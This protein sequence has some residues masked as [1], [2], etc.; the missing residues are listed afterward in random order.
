MLYPYYP[1]KST[2]QSPQ[3][4]VNHRFKCSSV[5]EHRSITMFKYEFSGFSLSRIDRGIYTGSRV[6]IL[7]LIH[8]KLSLDL[9]LLN[10][11]SDVWGESGERGGYNVFS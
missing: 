1:Y 9:W 6:S 2:L 8:R 11:S 4:L 5:Y 7:P 10:W 3:Y